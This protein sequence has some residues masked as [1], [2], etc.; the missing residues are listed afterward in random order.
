H[1]SA[2][3]NPQPAPSTAF[4]NGTPSDVPMIF[5]PA[6]ENFIRRFRARVTAPGQP[7]AELDTALAQYERQLAGMNTRFVR[8][9]ELYGINIFDV[10]D[11]AP[12]QRP[13]NDSPSDPSPL[14]HSDP[15][16]PAP[17]ATAEE[18]PHR[19]SPSPPSPGNSESRQ[20]AREQR[21]QQRRIDRR[22]E[23]Q[24]QR[25]IRRE[26]RREERLRQQ[27]R[28][29][30]FQARLEAGGDPNAVSNS[31]IYV[32]HLQEAERLIMAGDLNAF[33]SI[34]GR[35]DHL[36]VDQQQQ[37]P[38]AAAVPPAAIERAAQI[39][40][41]QRGHVA[42]DSERRLTPL[43]L[44]LFQMPIERL[45]IEAIE[46][47]Q[48][49]QELNQRMQEH[50]AIEARLAHAEAEVTRQT[51]RERRARRA[52]RARMREEAALLEQVRAERMN[53]EA[54]LVE[55][56]REE[57]RRTMETKKEIAK[58]E[59]EAL[60]ERLVVDRERR[61]RENWEARGGG[62]VERL[63]IRLG[64]SF[65]VLGGEVLLAHHNHHHGNP[66]K[67]VL[68]S[69]R[70]AN[71]AAAVAADKAADCKPQD[72]V[73]FT[74]AEDKEIKRVVRAVA[75]AE[76]DES[77]VARLTGMGVMNGV[78]RFADVRAATWPDGAAGVVGLE[79]RMTEEY[80]LIT[81]ER[82][83]ERVEDETWRAEMHAI[84]EY[85]LARVDG[86][87]GQRAREEAAREQAAR[88]QAVREEL[89]ART[90]AARVDMLEGM[91]EVIRVA[92][93]EQAERA[94][95]EGRT[96]AEREDIMER[97]EEHRSRAAR[98]QQAVREGLMGRTE[99]AEEEMTE[100]M[101]EVRSRAI[102]EE[103]VRM[104]LAERTG[105]ARVEEIE[106]IEEVRRQAMQ[107]EADEMSMALIR[108][109]GGLE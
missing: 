12:A 63:K 8:M 101:D 56:V 65:G 9:A 34:A 27:R 26:A 17:P 23:R 44:E 80:L 46:L 61:K 40:T 88:E 42:R 107:E 76:A 6:L 108:E 20:L 13:S 74:A 81:E 28:Q 97:M 24:R 52:R 96:E 36:E 77:R 32:A 39:E 1:G 41:Q 43:D 47:N 105:A 10:D 11:H 30:V 15:P 72:A 103:A 53:E 71:R 104:E 54:A 18:E 60:F 102:R 73:S 16:P 49:L 109:V 22:E 35:Q 51:R 70:A 2:P 84:S 99:A 25:E 68:D 33:N 37:R 93:R 98:R 5:P 57:R 21:R 90:E 86:G 85:L 48:L 45:P 29:E 3:P 83:G 95:L 66:T 58:M 100:R 4:E 79:S 69:N 92:M 89:A 38:E 55:R 14:L 106:R 64:E 75:E 59:M 78:M 50:A 62:A 7:A 31:H 67:S 19:V 91:R 87:D 94:G 82:E